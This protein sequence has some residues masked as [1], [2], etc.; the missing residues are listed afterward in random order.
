M[1]GNSK[2]AEDKETLTADETDVCIPDYVKI[3]PLVTA[4]E[5]DQHT[6]EFVY[7]DDDIK[8]EDMQ[9]VKQELSDENDT[10]FPCFVS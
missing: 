5:D 7:P 4:S 6:P 1:S 9:D 3:V 10:E 2:T 8:Q